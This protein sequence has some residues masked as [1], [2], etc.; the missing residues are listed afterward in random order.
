M[1]NRVSTANLDEEL[2]V[3]NIHDCEVICDDLPLCKAFT[4][5]PHHGKCQAESLRDTNDNDSP[6]TRMCAVSRNFFY[7]LYLLFSTIIVNW[8]D[9]I[10]KIYKLY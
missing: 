10:Q 1:G 4:Y 8:K 3:S 6:N 7:V 2:Q 9:F 5:D